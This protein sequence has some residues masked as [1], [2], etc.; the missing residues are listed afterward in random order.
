MMV[1]MKWRLVIWA[2]AVIA[3]AAAAGLAID[4]AVGGADKASGLAGVIAG[5]CELVA[6]LLGV[7]AW[8]RTRQGARI[9]EKTR[10]AA[11]A[12]RIG[13]HADTGVRTAAR[14]SRYIVDVHGAEG[15]QVGNGNIQHN[16]FCPPPDGLDPDETADNGR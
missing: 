9:G 12:G 10:A 6:S 4:A 1:R 3:V 13:T 2:A 5:F 8:A 16:S 7:A 15:V 11:S 14:S